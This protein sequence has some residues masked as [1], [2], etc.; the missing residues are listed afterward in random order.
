MPKTTFSKLADVTCVFFSSSLRLNST[1]MYCPSPLAGF[2]RRGKRS[3][4][5]KAHRSRLREGTIYSKESRLSL[6][7]STKS[8][9]GG[10]M[11]TGTPPAIVLQ[12]AACNDDA[13][14]KSAHSRRFSTVFF[15][16]DPFAGN[17]GLITS[18]TLRR[19]R[20]DSH[21]L[22]GIV[23]VNRRLHSLSLFRRIS[24]LCLGLSAAPVAPPQIDSVFLYVHTKLRGLLSVVSFRSQ[25]SSTF[26]CGA[27]GVCD[28]VSQ[29]RHDSRDFTRSRNWL[30][31]N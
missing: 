9:S 26:V 23:V 29:G 5:T 13:E 22:R 1:S 12:S 19:I 31:T 30:E 11:T 16:H 28:A 25:S 7:T 20:P 4:G 2:L 8:L 6:P 10:G 27:I 18:R 15:I 3:A 17:F 21:Q 14:A 24:T